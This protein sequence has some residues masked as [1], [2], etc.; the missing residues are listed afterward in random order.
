MVLCNE[1]MV[2]FILFILYHVMFFQKTMWYEIVQ[3]FNSLRCL[4]LE[5]SSLKFDDHRG[6][7]AG[8][9]VHKLFVGGVRVM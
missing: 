8:A 9:G 5:I 3:N 2:Y 1:F 4:V 6:F 7:H